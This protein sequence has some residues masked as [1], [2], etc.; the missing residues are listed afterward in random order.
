MVVLFVLK[1]KSQL[2][3]FLHKSYFK[4]SNE[5]GLLKTF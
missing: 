4:F 3:L 2:I 5:D 1:K